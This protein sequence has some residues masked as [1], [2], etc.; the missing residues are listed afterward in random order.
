MI[1]PPLLEMYARLRA[2]ELAAQ[3]GAR[4]PLAKPIAGSA[5]RKRLAQGLIDIGLR[6]DA[7]ASRAVLSAVEATPRHQGCD[8]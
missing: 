5:L 4:R 3:S 2:A 1:T 7:E 6:L 8:A